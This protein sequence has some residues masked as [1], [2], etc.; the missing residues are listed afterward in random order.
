MGN[1]MFRKGNAIQHEEVLCK[2]RI[3]T[4]VPIMCCTVNA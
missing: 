4:Q 3:P 2:F 1:K